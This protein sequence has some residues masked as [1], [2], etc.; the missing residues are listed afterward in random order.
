MAK[1]VPAL[2]PEL[3]GTLNISPKVNAVEARG[4][5]P[6]Y[7]TSVASALIRKGM[8][9]SRAIA[10]ARSSLAKTCA[11][12]LWGG[13]GAK[14]S[15][16]IQA[17]ACAATA[18][19]K[20][21]NLSVEA[22]PDAV[23]SAR[24]FERRIEL[25]TRVVSTR[26]SQPTTRNTLVAK[27]LSVK[28]YGDVTYADPGYRADGKARYPV[29]TAAHV[30][31]AAAYI[32][33]P[34]N[35]AKYKPH[36][37]RKVKRRIVVA[38]KRHGVNTT[39]QASV[40]GGYYMELAFNPSQPRL[41]AGGA[42]G[43]QW[44]PPGGGPA[45]QGEQA[46]YKAAADAKRHQA[47]EKAAKGAKKATKKKGAKKKTAGRGAGKRAAHVKGSKGHGKG[48]GKGKAVT[49]LSHAERHQLLVRLDAKLKAQGVSPRE[50]LKVVKVA[51]RHLEL[52][53]MSPRDR[54]AAREM[55]RAQATAARDAAKAAKG[56][57]KAA[58]PAK[59][60]KVSAAP[61]A[62]KAA[63]APKPAKVAKA[64]RVKV[65]RPAPKMPK[66]LQHR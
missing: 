60:A 36:Q 66:A 3:K 1:G 42:G 62:P 6:S 44:S 27:P 46:A 29:H 50:R 4:G 57:A 40:S 51:A 14:V 5:L 39:V 49:A 37:L 34:A 12:G 38:A 41:A 47:A 31:A 26:D 63:K 54:T 58:R 17:A 45:L 55:D 56:A 13:H 61:K 7:V 11:T 33:K 21:R 59:A 15:P 9:R 19:L 65:A 2:H 28:P 22:D 18:S 48:K 35:A 20:A 43:G 24:A 32:S 16:A 64:A 8:G 10:T 25:A 53:A 30:R 23:E 52:Q